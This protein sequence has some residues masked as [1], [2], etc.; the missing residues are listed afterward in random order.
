M[1]TKVV[2]SARKLR[3]VELVQ[4]GEPT[5]N[6]RRALLNTGPVESVGRTGL[7]WAYPLQKGQS[8]AVANWNC[9]VDIR[10]NVEHATKL[11]FDCFYLHWEDDLQA[12][13]LK[14]P[15]LKL[16]PI[17]DPYSNRQEFLLPSLLHPIY[18]TLNGESEKQIFV[19]NLHLNS[20]LQALASS[21]GFSHLNDL[22]YEISLRIRS[23]Q[24]MNWNS[25]PSDLIY[26]YDRGRI[27]FP[28]QKEFTDMVGGFTG[29]AVMD[30]FYGG[31]TKLLKEW[32]DHVSVGGQIE[33][34][35]QDIIWKPL[36]NNATWK[37]NFPGMKIL[38]KSNSKELKDMAVVFWNLFGC[39]S[40]TESMSKL[41]WRGVR[42]SPLKN[43]S[44]NAEYRISRESMNFVQKEFFDF[45]SERSKTQRDKP[46]VLF[47]WDFLT[48][49]IIGATRE[50]IYPDHSKYCE[51]LLNDHIRYIIN[52][53]PRFTFSVTKN[54]SF[55]V[56]KVI[57]RKLHKVLIKFGF[58]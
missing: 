17:D 29:F 15:N 40:S 43:F 38:T 9:E 37:K 50:S 36:L 48:T 42:L 21:V 46:K 16:I 44:S 51:D 12:T 58:K 3:D 57:L 14:V 54:L 35:H 19:K 8:Y 13:T 33:G 2:T 26:A 31:K 22:G 53:Y 28:A 32:F 5:N 20:A 25:L 27:L 55:A 10:Y 7:T 52:K 18:G 24:K 56:T 47:N 45:M 41:E 1:E 4:P 23:D 39:A 6:N 49:N 11:G 34:P 30:F